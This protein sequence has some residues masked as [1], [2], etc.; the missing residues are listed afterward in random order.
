MY[1]ILDHTADVGF[2]FEAPT[3]EAAIGEATRALTGLILGE[4]AGAVE[5]R[6][7]RDVIVSGE[8]REDLLYNYLSELIYLFDAEHFLA[9][10]AREVEFR[11]GALRVRV[12]GER[13]MR[14]RHGEI[15]MYVKAITYHQL[16]FECD[17]GACRGQV[18]V[19]I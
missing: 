1:T 19:D 11:P 4:S 8:S 13:Y 16:R 18:F 3:P 10:Q 7:T 5:P 2:S 12:A 14:D 9:A 15:Q 6:E 17:G